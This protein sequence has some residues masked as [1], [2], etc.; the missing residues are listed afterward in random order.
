MPRLYRVSKTVNY[1]VMTADYAVPQD[2]L[3]A[4]LKTTFGRN[5]IELDVKYE[6]KQVEVL[7]AKA[8]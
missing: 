4:Q 8:D 6:V 2:E 5:P 1:L 7:D 3:E